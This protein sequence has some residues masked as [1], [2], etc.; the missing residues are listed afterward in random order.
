MY[1]AQIVI[2]DLPSE[3]I[4]R[5]SCNT[6]FLDIIHSSGSPGSTWIST[7][8]TIKRPHIFCRNFV[9][10]SSSFFPTTTICLIPSRHPTTDINID[11]NT[12]GWICNSSPNVWHTSTA[13][14]SYERL[15]INNPNRRRFAADI[16]FALG[17]AES[18]SS[19]NR[20]ITSELSDVRKNPPELSSQNNLICVC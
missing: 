4:F 8:L 13:F 6:S 12:H 17:S 9:V 14:L 18:P 2:N 16:E 20:R 3:G 7:L 10:I 15:L 19:F 11:G 1:P 5:T